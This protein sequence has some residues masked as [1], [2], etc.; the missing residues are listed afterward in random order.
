MDNFG[1]FVVVF[2]VFLQNTFVV[3]SQYSLL[4][5]MILKKDCLTERSEMKNYLFELSCKLTLLNS[6]LI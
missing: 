4:R 5:V 1:I 2:F 3:T 6:L